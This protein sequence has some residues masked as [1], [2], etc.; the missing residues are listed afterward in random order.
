MCLT[1]DCHDATLLQVNPMPSITANLDQD[2]A[3]ALQQVAAVISSKS[4]F[5]P[6]RRR[7]SVTLLGSLHKYED[8]HIFRV[9]DTIA[10]R[11]APAGGH[12]VRWD[13]MHGKL[14]VLVHCPALAGFEHALRSQLPRGKLWKPAN[15]ILVGSVEAIPSSQHPDFLAAVCRTFPI[16]EASTFTLT[17]LEHEKDDNEKPNPPATDLRG[18]EQRLPGPPLRGQKPSPPAADPK[19]RPSSA[20][21]KL[22]AARGGTMP[23]EVEQRLTP[24]IHKKKIKKQHKAWSRT[25]HVKEQGR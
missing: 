16:V 24:R 9:M 18:V 10:R 21:T 11:A 15:S 3:A 12:F 25:V 2:T 7:F 22:K 1:R 8:A 19:Q 13:I 5:V 17:S 4:A 20:A 23:M 14:C 6:S